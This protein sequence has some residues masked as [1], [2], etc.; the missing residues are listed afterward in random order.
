MSSLATVW[1]LRNSFHATQSKQNLDL[2]GVNND[3]H[4]FLDRVNVLHTTD[5]FIDRL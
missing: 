1:L 4:F 3:L 5:V 2:F